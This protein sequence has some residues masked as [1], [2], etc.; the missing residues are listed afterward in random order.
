MFTMR[1]SLTQQAA[2]L[3]IQAVGAAP[4]T[5]EVKAFHPWAESVV[6]VA[7]SYLPPASVAPADG[8]HGLVARVAQGADY[9]EV[10]GA[11]LNL[12]AD[13]LTSRTGAYRMEIHVDTCPLPERKL[14]VLSGIGWLGKNCCVFVDGCGSYVALGE[15]VTSVPLP[16]S[17]TQHASRC[18]DCALCLDACPTGALIGPGKLDRSKCLSRITQSGEAIPRELRSTLGARLYGCDV[19]QEVCPHNAG[20]VPLN[21]EFAEGRFP[22][23]QPDLLPL[24]NVT[25][26]DFVRRIKP[27]SI[28]WVGRTRLRRNAAV[29]AGNIAS[30]DA[31]PE[32]CRMLNDPNH[33]LRPG[34][35]WALGRIGTTD[36]VWALR[37]SLDTERNPQS[38]QEIRDALAN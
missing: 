30:A 4:A 25:G 36:A 32:L 37:I 11:K 16:P 33:A 28:G 10:V 7:V 22:G 24:L 5:N 13:S 12:L 38:I 14:A 3:G 2:V 8:V 1:S 31:V 18:G 20:L 34:A 23:A 29:A 21:S 19:C 27:S 26:E 35:A 15:I 9:H 17:Q 6:C